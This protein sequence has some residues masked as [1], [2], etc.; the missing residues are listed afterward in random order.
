MSEHKQPPGLPDVVDEA[1][2]SPSWLPLLGLALLCLAA[3]FVAARQAIGREQSK[4]ASA[5]ASDGGVEQAQQKP[6][7]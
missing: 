4:P 2:R 7:L 1:G 6:A 5:A 3:L